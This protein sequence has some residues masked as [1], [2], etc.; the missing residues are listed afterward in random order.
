MKP[1]DVARLS[2][3]AF[4][5]VIEAKPLQGGRMEI[6]P[7]GVDREPTVALFKERRAVPVTAALTGELNMAEFA[8]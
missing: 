8:A 2:Q 1:N 5:T 3:T 7:K 6:A 4:E